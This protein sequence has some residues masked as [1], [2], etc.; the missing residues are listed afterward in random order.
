MRPP[1]RRAPRGARRSRPMCRAKCD[2]ATC[3]RCFWPDEGYTKGDLIAYYDAIAPF[4]LRY[5]R[6]RPAVLTRYP[7]GIKGKSFFQKDAPVFVPDWI[8][9]SRC[10]RR[11]PT[12]T[13]SSS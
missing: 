11:T 9:S 13:S 8:G 7:D 6:D 1:A 10:T 5:L 12:A 4:M 3:A 2:S